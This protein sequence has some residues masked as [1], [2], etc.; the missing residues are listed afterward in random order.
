MSEF[1]QATAVAPRGDGTYD[2]T[3]HDGWDIMGNA[4]GG[5]LIALAARAMGDAAGRPPLSLTA[6]YLAPGRVGPVTVDVDVVRAGRR[7]AVVRGTVVSAEH[8]PAMA[9]LGTFADQPGPEQAG[10]S[11]IDAAPPDLP[12]FEQCV[13]AGPPV[14]MNVSGFGHRVVCAY[15]P[16][17]TGFRE[18]N[19]TG[20]AMV[21]GWFEFVDDT[22]IDAFGLMVALDAFA[23]VCFNREEF[24]PSWAP[25]LELTTHIRETPAPGPLRCVFRSRFIQN[26][27][28]EEDGEVW[29][30]RGVL[31]AQSRQLAL[32][33]KP[34]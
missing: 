20:T 16:D 2:A 15:H 5:Y 13:P 24:P 17:D 23:P 12:P 9:L 25:T 11:V 3:I 4:N 29:D 8:G 31:V 27:M 30:S 19:P 10:P 32:I 6:H 1:E 28:F 21:R 22:D 26:G 14:A 18:G 34:M 33:P 7:M